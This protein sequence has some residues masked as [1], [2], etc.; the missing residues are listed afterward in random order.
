MCLIFASSEVR[1]FYCI[2]GGNVVKSDRKKKIS[3]ETREKAMIFRSHRGGV[4]Y[5][6]ENTMPAFRAALAQKFEQIETDPQY[7]KDGVIVLMHDSTINRTCR[8]DDGSVIGQPMRVCDMTYAELLNYDAGIHKGMQFKGTRIPR[9][10]ELLELLDGTDVLLDLDKKITAEE[11]DPLLHLVE[12]YN[13]KVEFS[14]ADTARIRKILSIL[15]DALINYDGKNTEE[16]LKKIAALVPRERLSVWVYLDKPNFAWLTDRDK[17]SPEV[18]ERVRKYA[19][20][21]IANVNC[22]EDVREAMLLGADVIE[23]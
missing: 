2:T 6:P 14:C 20:L 19:A 23:V 17:A 7:T 11:I 22:A 13:V 3:E 18:C 5:T 16:E 1:R 9:L 12:K 21:G 4:Y 8:H 15:P 10:E